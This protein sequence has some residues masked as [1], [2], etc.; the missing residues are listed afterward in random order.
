MPELI[1]ANEGPQGQ[2]G[3]GYCMKCFK[4][5]DQ[6]LAQHLPYNASVANGQWGLPNRKMERV[7]L[8][9]E[10]QDWARRNQLILGSEVMGQLT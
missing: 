6:S 9:M 3:R 4:V 7:L 1:L 8:F 5:S 2:M 10:K